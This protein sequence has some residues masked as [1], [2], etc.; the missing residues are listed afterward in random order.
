VRPGGSF[1]PDPAETRHSVHAE[2]TAA[3]AGDAAALGRLLGLAR[4]RLSALVQRRLRGGH[5]EPWIEDVVQES[6]VDV[7]RSYRDCRAAS[8]AEAIAWIT[9]IG[10]REVAELFRREGR[11][12]LVDLS[13][14]DTVAAPGESDDPSPD[15]RR[16]FLRAALQ[17]LGSSQHRLLWS[18]LVV[19]LTWPQVGAELRISHTAAKRRYQRLLR[20]LRKEAPL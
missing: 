18:R 5:T 15:P 17:R 12:T 8:E 9:A 11:A 1:P 19:A 16:Q 13:Y 2:L 20:R 4:E 7:L 14:T 10:R 6:L 3:K